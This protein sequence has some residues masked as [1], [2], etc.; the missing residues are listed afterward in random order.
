MVVFSLCFVTNCLL[1]T[2]LLTFVNRT[3]LKISLFLREY[4][5][6]APSAPLCIRE[7]P[8]SNPGAA[9]PG[10]GFFQRFPHTITS[11]YVSYHRWGECWVSINFLVP[12]TIPPSSPVNVAKKAVESL[13]IP[14]LFGGEMKD[15]YFCNTHYCKMIQEQSTK[16]WLTFSSKNRITKKYLMKRMQNTL[17]MLQRKLMSKFVFIICCKI[18]CLLF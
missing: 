18:Q 7:V 13:S 14:P 2:G 4:C 9:W 11:W 16:M 1:S 6:Q 8:G 12:T 3:K 17:E 5:G 15:P 10:V